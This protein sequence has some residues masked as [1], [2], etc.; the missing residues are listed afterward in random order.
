M[1]ETSLKTG[2]AN[3]PTVDTI[4]ALLSSPDDAVLV[5]KP[6]TTFECRKPVR[7]YNFNYDNQ[8]ANAAGAPR[9]AQMDHWEDET[10]QLP[11]LTVSCL[12][13][14][15]IMG[16]RIGSRSGTRHRDGQLLL[17]RKQQLVPNSFA[18]M[19]GGYTLPESYVLGSTLE[20]P[21]ELQCPEPEGR[22][23]GTYFHLGSI[24]NHFGHFLLEGLTRLWALELLEAAGQDCRFIMYEGQLQPYQ[25]EI[26]ALA[27]VD[28]DR[29]VHAPHATTVERLIVADP[30]YRTHRW[31]RKEQDRVWDRIASGIPAEEDPQRKIF[32]SRAR[33]TDRPLENNDEVEALFAAAGYDIV[34]PETMSP[35]DQIAMVR[36]CRSLAGC[37]GSQMYL[38]GFQPKG[39]RNVILAPK[40]FYLKDDALISHFRH[41]RLS[42]IFGD[43]IDLSAP[44]PERSW[45]CPT[46]DIQRCLELHSKRD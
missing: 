39:G 33:T 23:E 10:L 27:G 4:Q 6:E 37:V 12:H 22:L 35:T 7:I 5:R 38:A 28:A 26:L 32:L 43:Y 2:M 24:H 42:V 16:G 30:A 13:D 1:A 44:K 46:E 36:Q 21:F 15:R 14:A 29:I 40:N 18:I 25:E 41:H 8:I 31:V 11:P 17:T 20:E 19:D 34:S 9:V 45:T 3:L